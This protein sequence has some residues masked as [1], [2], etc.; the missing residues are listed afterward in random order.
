MIAI[1]FIKTILDFEGCVQILISLFCRLHNS[2]SFIFSS[3]VIFPTLLII[4]IARAVTRQLHTPDSSG[5]RRH[6]S[7]CAVKSVMGTSCTA[8]ILPLHR[9]CPGLLP[10][11]F[12]PQLRHCFALFLTL[13]FTHILL[14]LWCPKLNVI[15]LERPYLC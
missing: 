15:L 5:T 1:L 14:E 8:A 2:T 6:A 11:L 12:P 9:F 3:Y 13:P 4:L 7:C 10:Q